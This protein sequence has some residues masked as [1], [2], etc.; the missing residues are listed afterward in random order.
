MLVKNWMI[1]PAITVNI[2]GTMQQ[3][4]NLMLEHDISILPVLENGKLVGIV[5]DSDIRS[6]SPS[7]VGPLTF[8]HVLF[9]ISRI[10]VGAFMTREVVTVPLDFTVEETA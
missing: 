6:A 4:V 5:T 9:Q 2:N 7:D 10:A 1:K 3:A 8:R